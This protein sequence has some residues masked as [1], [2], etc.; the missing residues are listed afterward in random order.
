MKNSKEKQ[1]EG[2]MSLRAET[3]ATQKD[4][5][6]LLGIGIGAY[7]EYEK[8]RNRLP[9]EFLPKIAYFYDIDFNQL[10]SM[11]T[12]KKKFNKSEISKSVRKDISQAKKALA[13]NDRKVRSYFNRYSKI[14]G[15]LIKQ[16]K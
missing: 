13:E 7:V 16:L 4:L 1:G 8:G 3:T 5:S 10:V 2:L 15:E 14:T 9:L 11:L 6:N 12:S